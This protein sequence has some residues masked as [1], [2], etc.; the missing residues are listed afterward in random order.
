MTRGGRWTSTTRGGGG[1][2]DLEERQRR[3]SLC[4]KCG[5]AE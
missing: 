5:V 3:S 2:V 1:R 4:G